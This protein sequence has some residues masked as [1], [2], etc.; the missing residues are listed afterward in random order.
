[1]P[2]HRAEPD[3]R[4]APERSS[5]VEADAPLA[6][7]VIIEEEALP[8]AEGVIRS[9]KLAGKSLP[10]AILILAAPIFL[11]Q[12]AAACLGLV[13][14]ILA[15]NLPEGIVVPALD[16]LGIGS[17]IAWFIG[18]AMAG[19]GVGGQA[20][21]ARGIGGGRSAEA[22]HAL[23][24]TMS[25][26]LIWGALVGATLWFAA[27]SIT[28]WC[29]LTPE[30]AV[31]GIDYVR[32]LAYSMPFCG[33]MMV[34]SMT[35]CG[36]GE[37]TRPALIAVIANVVNIILS[38]TLAGA[39]ITLGGLRLPHP[40]F[41]LH[42]TGIA[43]GTAVSYVVGAVLI[44][45]LQ[46]RGVKDLRL[47]LRELPLR[48]AMIWRIVRVGVPSFLDGISMWVANLFVL[49]FIGQIAAAS[50]EGAGLQGAHIITVQW[51]M[52]SIMPG[53]AIGIAG[54]AL[55]GQYLG[56]RN[57]DMAQKAVLLCAGITCLIMGSMGIVYILAGG[58]LTRI[59][60]T[61][62]VHVE[63][64]PHLLFIAGLSQVFFAIMM[65]LRQGLRGVGDTTWT[66]ILTT[67]S[68]YGVR[69]PA[70]WLFGIYLHL[71]IE[72]IWI[73]LCGEM[74]VRAA[75]FSARFFQGGWKRIRV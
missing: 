10:A 31:M 67:V 71:G 28:R 52:F 32:I 74:V 54:G 18:I 47:E 40:P 53:F 62:P 46:R 25:L 50:A 1:L 57:P 41:D 22:H 43:M 58:T 73:G 33:V 68:S 14:K 9:G 6:G 19:L 12:T 45:G 26:S 56:A 27:P 70:A 63:H 15:G 44:V 20:I 16:G 35:L 66:F 23:G 30:A 61:E 55:A 42:V 60:S 3:D 37:T 75:M 11:Q 8:D 7:L 39:D 36:A 49:V 4:G 72:G 59:I 17:Y 13:D 69:L 34:G 29:R 51:E 24:Q 21:V 38:W 48:A 64:V 65:V 5:A 2:D